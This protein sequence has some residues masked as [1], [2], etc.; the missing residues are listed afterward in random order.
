VINFKIIVTAIGQPKDGV[1]IVVISF[2][3]KI[4]SI[5]QLFS[6]KGFNILPVHSSV[7]IYKVIGYREI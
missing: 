4:I 6:R 7:I 3:L 5:I 2:Q 1:Y